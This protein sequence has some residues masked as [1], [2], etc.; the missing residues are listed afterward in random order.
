MDKFKTLLENYPDEV[1]EIINKL[2][3]NKFPNKRDKK[4][5]FKF[6]VMGK[7]YDS[8]IFTKNYIEFIKDISNIHPYEMFNNSVVK[9]YISKT[10]EGMKQSHKIKDDFYITGYSP[11]NRKINHIK[12]L[13]DLLEINLKEI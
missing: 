3:Y 4:T 10:Y 12:K 8:D 11:T 6:K 9:G 7:N 13:C 5:I 1:N 2:Y